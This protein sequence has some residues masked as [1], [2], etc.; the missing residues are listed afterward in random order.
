MNDQY[1][2]VY[3]ITSSTPAIII[4]I[5]LFIV[6]II[7][8]L[9]QYNARANIGTALAIFAIV[10]INELFIESLKRIH[11]EYKVLKNN[12][13]PVH[14][15]TFSSRKILQT[16]RAG[17]DTASYLLKNAEIKFFTSKLEN[18]E[19]RRAEV[20]KDELLKQ[21][22]EVVKWI[23]GNY[24]T[25]ID[26]FASYI[27][28][29]E[30]D[31]HYMR[32]NKF[33]NDDIINLLFWT[34][35]KFTPDIFE[36][37][38]TQLA[39]PGVF[40][41]LV[42]G[43]N[44]E[45]KKY[46]RD[47]TWDVL[48]RHFA[49]N[50]IGL[51][52]EFSE[53]VTGLSKHKSSN[54]VLVGEAGTGKASLV[55]Y[56]AYA[57]FIGLISSALNKK[58]VYEFFADRLLSGVA[59]AGELE[60]RVAAILSEIAFS[61]DVLIFI[62]NI[63]NIFGGGGLGFDISGVLEEYL[64]SD[65]V[66]IIGST[67]PQGF[68]EFIK[69]KAGASDLFE[70]VDLSEMESG[71]VMLLLTEKAREIEAKYGLSIKYS[72]LKQSV[73]L[74]SVYFPEE[75][76]P[77]KAIKLLE[78][79]ASKAEVDKKRI[80][81]GVDVLNLVQE[82]TKVALTEPDDVEKDLL[83][84]LEDKIHSRIIGQEEAVTA[85]ADALRRA[86]SGFEDKNRPISVLLF[87]GPTGVG[88][89]EMAKALAAEY[90]GHEESMIRLDMSEYQ[91]QDQMDRLI[92]TKSAVEYVSN[93]LPE[94]VEKQPF[95]LILLDEFEKANPILLNIFLQVF[96]EGRLT[97]NQGKTVTFKETIIIATSNAGTE[98]L[99]EKEKNSENVN[100]EELLDYLLRNNLFTP[101][102]LNRFDDVVVFEFLTPDDVKKI[103]ALI[104]TESFNKLSE[105]HQIKINF[106]EKVL[107]KIVSSAY[108]AEFG[109]RNIRRYIENDIESYL[110]KQIL[111]NNIKQ[112]SEVMLSVDE[113][114]NFIVR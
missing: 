48:S 41:S 110:S 56:L 92:G 18:F 38:H 74:S 15:M 76:Y 2:E 108:N 55:E 83:V 73:V 98:L 63:E 8:V 59:N 89:T 75:F 30:E 37:K 4:R 3:K 31:T 87:L 7:F 28:L 44:Y 81:D 100:K 24:I 13:D 101:E 6:S 107:T 33:T 35:K 20:S 29:S 67:T 43:W 99:R 93:S 106:D 26:L 94:M 17:F 62:R 45:L 114:G 77:G 60:S 65:R 79:V 69:P 113:G 9:I 27:L 97:T 1:F 103:A 51:E 95:S 22:F 82:K 34:R 12:S 14:S 90:F 72:A 78:D 49:P 47:L 58:R 11:P 64:T 88:K 25:D 21:A 46:S 23:K 32:E 57:S 19:L 109:A 111:E 112:S 42:F 61:G 86:R 50:I 40:D 16:T 54:V 85:V 84:H 66:R 80:I 10:L 96:D 71:K 36:M 39:G 68:S 102:L 70:K 91:T 5:F 104:L 105:D 52:R 53:L